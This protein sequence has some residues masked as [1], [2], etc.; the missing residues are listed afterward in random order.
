MPLRSPPSRSP[1]FSSE[2][3]ATSHIIKFDHPRLQT[4]PPVIPRVTPWPWTH[5]HHGQVSMD[6]IDKSAWTPWTSATLRLIQK[7]T[8]WTHQHPTIIKFDHPRIQT[9][10]PVIP[11]IIKKLNNNHQQVIYLHGRIQRAGLV[12][13]IF[14]SDPGDGVGYS[15]PGAVLASLV[16]ERESSVRCSLGL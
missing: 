7:V 11:R 5:Q 12:V 15:R 9:D 14:T 8:P 2:L 13:P 3:P 6:T 4:D 10:P 1:D 16:V